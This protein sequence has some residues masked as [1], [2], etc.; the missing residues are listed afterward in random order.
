MADTLR[1]RITLKAIEWMEKEY[2][3]ADLK[4]ASDITDAILPVV[5]QAIQQEREKAREHAWTE[6]RKFS[7]D[8]DAQVLKLQGELD[9]CDV[10]EYEFSGGDR[11]HNVVCSQCWPYDT[12]TRRLHEILMEK[13]RALAEKDAQIAALRET[14]KDRTAAAQ[15]TANANYG[16][17]A[18]ASE[19]WLRQHP[20]QDPRRETPAPPQ[21]QETL[22]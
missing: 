10:C 17:P 20:D 11:T 18:G 21:T 6:W 3:G 14:L 7:A 13:N 19:E 8:R 5:E 22:K 12:L 4:A 16:V 15:A 1:E 2:G 9:T